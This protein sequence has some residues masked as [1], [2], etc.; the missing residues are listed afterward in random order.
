MRFQGRTSLAVGPPHWT[1]VGAFVD[2]WLEA[3]RSLPLVETAS[4]E[5]IHYP[6]EDQPPNCRVTFVF[7]ASSD[8]EAR[9]IAEGQIRQAGLRGG[10]ARVA[11]GDRIGWMG[12]TEVVPAGEEF[13]S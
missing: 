3:L 13:D 4:A 11:D 8:D 5:V 2:G 12:S 6:D 9:E 10:L 1:E 7:E